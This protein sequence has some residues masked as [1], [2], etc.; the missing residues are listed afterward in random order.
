[1]QVGSTYKYESTNVGKRGGVLRSS[2]EISVMEREQREYIF[3]LDDMKKLLVKGKS[4]PTERR[5]P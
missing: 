2:E 4:F 3:L 5:Y 1:M